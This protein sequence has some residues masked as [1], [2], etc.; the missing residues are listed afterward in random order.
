MAS[1]R[2]GVSSCFDDH[3]PTAARNSSES[4]MAQTGL[5]PVAGRPPLFGFDNTDRDFAMFWYYRRRKPRGS[6]NFRV[7]CAN[8]VTSLNTGQTNRNSRRRFWANRHG[9]EIF[10]TFVGDGRIARATTLISRRGGWPV[11][12]RNKQPR[13]RILS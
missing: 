2:L 7:G 8:R 10:G 12:R 4:R 1:D 3:V 9:S 11:V 6:A 13:P 5:R